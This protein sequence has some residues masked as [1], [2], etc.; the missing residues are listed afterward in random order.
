MGHQPRRQNYADAHPEIRISAKRFAASPYVD[1]YATPATVFGVYAGR[2]YPLTLGADPVEDYWHLRSKAALFDVPERPLQVEGADAERFLDR[3]LTRDV[4]AIPPRKA[5]Y[6]LACDDRGGIVMDGVL[7]RWSADRFW[8]VLADGE[9]VGR[10]DAST[11]GLEV[12][13]SDPGSWVTQ[14]QGPTS[15][16]VFAAA[17]D[18]PP[19]TFPY[20]SVAEVRMG[21]QD[22]LVSRTGWSGELGFEIYTLPGTD[23]LD[24]WDHVLAAGADHGLRVQGLESLGIRRIEAGILDNGTDMDP[25]LTPYAAGLGAFV[26]L[27]KAEFTGRDA[28]ASADRR[29]RLLGISGP[30]MPTAGELLYRDGEPVGRV[31]T[32]AWSPY[33]DRGIGYVLFA[34]P[35]E[36]S[37]TSVQSTEGAVFDVSELPFYDREKAI[38]R[39]V[40][41]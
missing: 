6:A 21:G 8:Y 18:E 9:F 11:R 36:W 3:V 1:R 16:D 22:V 13:I 26:D 38:P 27:E 29:T 23:G 7:I 19:S 28:L 31:T 12:T 37:S 24:L 32:G 20:F 41:I 10:L 30:A 2:L 14:I 40:E 33:L 25:S 39:G 15:L 34:E 5:R 17:C 4:A 35:G